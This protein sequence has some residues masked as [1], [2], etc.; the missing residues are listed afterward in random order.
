MNEFKTMRHKMG[1]TLIQ[2]HKIYG[3]PYSTLQKWEYGD[4]KPADYV[5][6]MMWEIYQIHTK[7]FD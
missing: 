2:L 7:N 5:L 3:I 1:L 4:N 6:K